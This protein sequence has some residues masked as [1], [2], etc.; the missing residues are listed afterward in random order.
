MKNKLIKAI[1]RIITPYFWKYTSAELTC[2]NIAFSQF[3]EDSVLHYLFKNNYSGFYV[4][5]GAFHPMQFSNTYIFYRR[6]WRGIAIDANPIV[7]TTFKRFRP[8][9][10]FINSAVGAN[11]KE[12]DFALFSDPALNCAWDQ[13]D[14]VP[15]DVRNSAQRIKVS[16]RSLSSIFAEYDLRTIDF[17]NVDCEG[18]D[19]EVLKSNDWSQWKPKVVCVEDHNIEWS[20]SPIAKYLNQ[21]GYT[22]ISRVML[23]SIFIL[24]EYS[25]E[26]N[27]LR[28][29]I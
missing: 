11:E 22:L 29:S 21:Q 20:C 12:L 10:I 23:S 7:K 25:F 26:V 14:N 19:L 16:V 17:L 18:Y 5:V 27:V 1:R 2:A 9:D 28:L 13:V 24:K 6:G 3:G 8:R 15:D 4:D